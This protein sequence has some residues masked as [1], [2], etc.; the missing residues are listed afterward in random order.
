[1]GFAEDQ[2]RGS[3]T[4]QPLALWENARR[5]ISRP[6]DLWFDCGV[7]DFED[8]QIEGRIGNRYYHNDEVLRCVIIFFLYV[9]VDTGITPIKIIM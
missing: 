5:A 9:I 6:S 3:D 2:W 1:M 8:V 7:Y 4:R